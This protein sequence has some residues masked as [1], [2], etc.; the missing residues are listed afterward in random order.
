MCRVRI[1]EE[2]NRFNE[3][4]FIE[5]AAELLHGCLQGTSRVRETT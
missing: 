1:V 2:R 5:V 3:V 4:A